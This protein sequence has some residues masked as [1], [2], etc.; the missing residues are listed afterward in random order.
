MNTKHILLCLLACLAGQLL[1]AT[2]DLNMFIEKHRFLAADDET[3]LLVDYQIPYRS[4]TFIA[5][6]GGFFAEL[7]VS[8]SI[9]NEDSIVYSQEVTDNIGIRNRFDATSNRKFYLNRLSYILEPGSYTLSFIAT[10]RNSQKSFSWE[11]PVQSLDNTSPISDLELSSAVEA[12]STQYLSKFKRNNILYR[13]EPSIIFNKSETDF[14]HLFYEIY[15]LAEERESSAFLTISVEREDSLIM[16]LSND[17]TL[18]RDIEAMTMRIPIGDLP[19]GRY[20]GFLNIQV[21]ERLEERRFEFVVMEDVE[22]YQ[23]I[24]PNPDDEARLM[25]YF[26]GNRVPND[27]SN[28]SL[29]AKK[30][31]ISSF[32]DQMGAAYQST[33]PAIMATIRD[34]IDHANRRFTHFNPGWTTDMGRIYIRYGAPDELESDESSDETRFVR[35]DYQIWKYRTKANAVY[36]FVDH[37]MNGNYRLIYVSGDDMEVTNPSWQNFVGDDFDTTK[38]RN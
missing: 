14:L 27:W 3:I 1:L 20:N 35:K 36:L 4:L 7:G 6:H 15:S 2:G 5:Q 34:R 29:E 28:M 19:A 16:D 10:D 30:R 21:G 33:V 22:L 25:R 37:L 8:V 32:W 13:S 12:D 24:M 26:I 18:S 31:F 38:L 9:A 11:V 23:A 17:I